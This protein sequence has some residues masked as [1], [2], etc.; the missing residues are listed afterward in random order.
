MSTLPPPT[1]ALAVIDPIGAWLSSSIHPSAFP[2]PPRPAKLAKVPRLGLRMRSGRPMTTLTIVRSSGD[3][4]SLS[5]RSRLVAPNSSCPARCFLRLAPVTP[6][7]LT[8]T[9]APTVPPIWPMRSGWNDA[10]NG[11][12]GILSPLKAT[13]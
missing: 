6:E 8:A 12:N 5:F 9:F 4:T 1:T 3:F 11:G 7:P 13:S 10:T 2:A